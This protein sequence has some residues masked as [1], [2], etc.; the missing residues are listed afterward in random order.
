LK[1][2]RAIDVAF[3]RDGA[4]LVIPFSLAL[5]AGGDAEITQPNPRAASVA[6]RICAAIVRPTHGVA[7]VGDF[8]TRLQPPQAKRMVGFVDRAGFSGDDHAL[9]CEVAFRA[10]V[11]NLDKSAAQARAALVLE[12]LG[13]SAYARAIALAL[14]ADV[15]LVVLDQPGPNV[16]RSVRDIA[17]HAAIIATVASSS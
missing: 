10:E 8:E 7:Y 9:R 3:E 16:A 17:P 6:A 14:V 11:W 2:F 13:K 12:A 15:A 1:I 5:E 4:A